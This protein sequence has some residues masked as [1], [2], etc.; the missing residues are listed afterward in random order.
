MEISLD[1]FKKNKRKEVKKMLKKEEAIDPQVV[2]GRN[3]LAENYKPYM[4]AKLVNNVLIVVMNDGSIL[5][6]SNATEEDYYAIKS[7]GD[8]GDILSII[9]TKEVAEARE[10]KQKEIE[11]AVNINKGLSVLAQ[12]SDFVVE[13]NSV[14]LAGTS[15]SMPDLLVEEFLTI[16]NSYSDY[17]IQQTEELLM[18]SGIYQALKRFFLWCCLNPRA[19][20][21]NELYRFLKDNSFCITSQGFFLALRNVVTVKQ[22]GSSTE[23]VD[24]VSNAYNKVRAV[25]KKNPVDFNVIRENGE[26][27]IS[28]S[29][30]RG[31]I[32][33][34]L[35]DL[36][37]NMPEMEGNRYTDAWTGTFDIR[38]GKVVS[39]PMEECNW[40]TQDCAAAGLHFTSD[41]IHYVGCGDTSVLVMINPMK[42]VGI[43]QHKGRCYEY[44]PIMTVPRDEATQI[45]HDSDFDG[46]E[47]DEAYAIRE[48]EDL[49]EKVKAGFVA[50][51]NKYEFN[52]PQ[53]SSSEI[54]NIILSLE[55]MQSE[56]SSRVQII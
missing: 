5:S 24:F 23:L 45:L 30:I 26:L 25:W 53:I 41:Q 29:E 47:L 40:S 37:D 56:L 46:L 33:G 2:F 38:V 1:W 31:T 55:E 48:L 3:I 15:R 28:T 19:E 50:E 21:A 12:L 18:E 9:A 11:K 8:I 20:V 10:I 13:G 4:S 17:T 42:V 54:N 49:T 6:K 7:A 44:L 36:Y 16:V 32:I 39:M 52:L 43:G 35:K 14:Y 22:E 27:K 51:A 34:N